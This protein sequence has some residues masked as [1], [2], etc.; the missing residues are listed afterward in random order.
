M[1][2]LFYYLLVLNLLY[3]G[4]EY[5]QPTH[6]SVVVAALPE[7]LKTLELLDVVAEPVLDEKRQDDSVVDDDLQEVVENVEQLALSCFTLGPFKDELIVQQIRESMA[8]DI[9]DI[10]VRV[11]EESEKPRYWIYIPPLPR[12]KEAK[13]VARKLKRSQLKDYYVVLSGET[14]NSSQL[15]HFRETGYAN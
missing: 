2:V 3:A 5:V 15:G 14:K 4:W 10:N 7:G 6:Q 13:S 9:E 11:L 12:H 1:R 8:E